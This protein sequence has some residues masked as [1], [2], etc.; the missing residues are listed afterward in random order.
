MLSNLELLT[1]HGY[2]PL[3]AIVNL[4]SYVVSL[5]FSFTLYDDD[6]PPELEPNAIV[7][8]LLDVPVSP[9]IPTSFF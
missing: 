1:F 2:E 8:G 7:Y 6:D 5:K 4:L 9:T 3:P